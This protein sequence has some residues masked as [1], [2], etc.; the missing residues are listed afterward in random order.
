MTVSFDH[1]VIYAH[2]RAESANFFAAV[3]GLPEPVESGQF[4]TVRLAD[5]VTLHFARMGF[6]RPLI[7]QHYA[8]TLS[9]AE[10][11]QL[12]KRLTER[13]VEHWAD[14]RG[15]RPGCVYTDGDRRGVFFLD[16]SGHQLEALTH[17]PHG[18]NGGFS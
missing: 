14:A 15:S 2:D 13:E 11:D 10:F 5:G 1:T 9:D 18:Q 12:Y 7:T 16:P 6:G 8:F 3:F 4:L 17:R